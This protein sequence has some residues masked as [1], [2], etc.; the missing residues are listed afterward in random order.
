MDK[1]GHT[2]GLSRVVL[3]IIKQEEATFVDLIDSAYKS[4][5]VGA[6]VVRNCSLERRPHHFQFR[7]A[8]QDEAEMPKIESPDAEPYGDGNAKRHGLTH[9]ETSGGELHGGIHS[10]QPVELRLLGHY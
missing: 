9:A 8:L 6:F 10:P 1:R 3:E 7:E 4:L 2:I 5:L